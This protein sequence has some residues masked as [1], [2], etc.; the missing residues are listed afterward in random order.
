LLSISFYFSVGIFR[1]ELT[2]LAIP[3]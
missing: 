1:L 2:A 3:G